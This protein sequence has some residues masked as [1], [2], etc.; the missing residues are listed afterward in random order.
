MRTALRAAWL[1]LLLLTFSASVAAK[2][3]P[4]TQTFDISQTVMTVDVEEGITA[5]DVLSTLRS[6]AYEYNI[7]LVSEQPLS[8]ELQNRG[9]ETGMLHIMQF[10]NPQD[11]LEMVS[12]NPIFAAYMPCRIALVEHPESGQLQLMMMD[13][14][15]LINNTPLPPELEKMASSISSTLKK[16]VNAAAAGEF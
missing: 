16:M 3:A 13:L 4:P 12:Y 1:P 2:E 11:A 15:M 14:D 8:Q 6:K 9:I 7:K 5:D 10:C